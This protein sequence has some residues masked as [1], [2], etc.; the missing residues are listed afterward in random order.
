MKS[1]PQPF[2][3]LTVDACN[4]QLRQLNFFFASVQGIGKLKHP[5]EATQVVLLSSCRVVLVGICGRSFH[6]WENGNLSRFLD[7]I[8]D[9]MSFYPDSLV[10]L[11]VAGTIADTQLYIALGS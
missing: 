6:S 9:N 1:S 11:E 8:T 7:T 3:F 5:G 4:H 10:S 2:F